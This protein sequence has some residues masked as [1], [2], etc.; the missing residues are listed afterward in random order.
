MMLKSVPLIIALSLRAISASKDDSYYMAGSGNPN[1]DLKMFW[2]DSANVLQDLDQFSSLYVQ[3]HHCAWTMMQYPD[4]DGS[5][6]ESD[7]WY[8]NKM[9][10]M[11]ANVAF[12]L[13][14]SLKGERFW[15]CGKNTYIKSFYTVQG[16][17][18]FAKAMYNA[19]ISDFANYGSDDDDGSA[20]TSSCGGGQGVGCTYSDGFALLNYGSDSC[21]PAYATGVSDNLYELNQAMNGAQCIQIYDS[22]SY[23]G[24]IYDTPLE[25]L[26]YSRS[27]FYQNF[28]SP[29]GDCPDPYGRLAFYQENFNDG[30]KNQVANDPIVYKMKI[31]MD[32]TLFLIGTCMIA[33]AVG[34]LYA[35]K[36]FPSIKRSFDFIIVR[37]RL[38]RKR[39]SEDLIEK[40]RGVEKE[41]PDPTSQELT[42]TPESSQD[43]EDEPSQMKTLPVRVGTPARSYTKPLASTEGSMA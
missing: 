37:L 11:G 6:D 41:Q 31:R 40:A 32:Q 3:F 16:F 12:S 33:F 24:Y 29:E 43:S 22:K 8:Q 10:P 1:V 30:V 27:C 14:G 34:I 19:G 5:V 38:P 23:S 2:K 13:Y 15:G 39:R 36:H 4:E 28:F 25:L 18:H 26:A 21:D 17:E 20:V 35:D 7:Y 42:P 9:P